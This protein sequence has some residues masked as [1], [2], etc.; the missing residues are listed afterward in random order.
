MLSKKNIGCNS[1]FFC[2]DFDR[3]FSFP[4]GKFAC[5]SSLP[6]S[7]TRQVGLTSWRHFV[8]PARSPP[9]LYSPS[10][11]QPTVQE[12]GGWPK[13]L[14]CIGS[15]KV[16]NRC[17]FPNQWHGRDLPSCP[18]FPVALSSFR[19]GSRSQAFRPG[20]LWKG[21]YEITAMICA[22]MYYILLECQL[23]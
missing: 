17:S 9:P 4:S 10:L 23:P 18:V 16:G 20:F 13:V 12:V 11:L 21:F 3:R 19:R 8:C 2:L 1:R 7:C 14:Y 22:E 15:P 6:I 5:H